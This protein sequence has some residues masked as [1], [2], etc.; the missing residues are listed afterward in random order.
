MG[1]NLSK[2]GAE[3]SGEPPRSNAPADTLN[4]DTLDV[5]CAFCDEQ[6]LVSNFAHA[7]KT[8][9]SAVDAHAAARARR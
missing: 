4:A 8:V 2:S 1:H 7:S 5:I 6:T 3:K 9:A